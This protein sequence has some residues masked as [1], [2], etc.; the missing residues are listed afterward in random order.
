[1]YALTADGLPAF[2]RATTLAVAAADD[3][4][5]PTRHT[6]AILDLASGVLTNLVGG[7]F[8]L[9]L[10]AGVLG[11]ALAPLVRRRIGLVGGGAAWSAR[12]GP[13]QSQAGPQAGPQAGTRSGT[14]AGTRTETRPK[15][16]A[17]EPPQRA[18]GVLQPDT[19][20]AG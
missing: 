7:L 17:P 16:A 15:A 11:V 18:G 5:N 2:E 4:S 3:R 20:A 10:L 13:P 8:V 1:M 6:A 14:Q 9:Y 19:G 12:T